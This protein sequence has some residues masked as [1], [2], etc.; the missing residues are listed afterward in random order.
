MKDSTLLKNKLKAHSRNIR[1]GAMILFL[2]P[3]ISQAD[4]V[5]QNP[6]KISPRIELQ[7]PGSHFEVVKGGN[8]YLNAFLH[9]N[10]EL[11]SYRI[12]IS[13]GGVKTDKYT[14]TFSSYLKKDAKGNA[15]PNISGMKSAELNFE[16]KVEENTIVGDYSLFLHLRDKSG[17][18]Y[19]V[20][21]DF[22]VS[23]H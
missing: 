5:D 12:V 6:D 21:R 3:A 7:S 1:L 18:K 10:Q 20:K 8:I 13:K 14:N 11:D 16:I 17:N 19:T 9:D 2:F 23:R 22:Y 4:N 15:L